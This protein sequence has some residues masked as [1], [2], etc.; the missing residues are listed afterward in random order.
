MAD[1]N[2]RPVLKTV[3][4]KDTPKADAPKGKYKETPKTGPKE[5]RKSA[6]DMAKSKGHDALSE[7]LGKG[8]ASGISH[9]MQ[10]TTWERKQQPQK[11]AK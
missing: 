8:M 5:A 11:K 9:A 4:S 2:K 6:A 1:T 3:N 7:K 10:S